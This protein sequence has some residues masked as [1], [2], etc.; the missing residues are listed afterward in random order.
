MNGIYDEIMCVT[1]SWNDG[2]RA[3]HA[4]RSDADEWEE[5][6]PNGVTL[7]GLRGMAC[8]GRQEFR[9]KKSNRR[10]NVKSK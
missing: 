5:E 10:N 2:Y 9:D 6:N 7:K 4:S 1:P 8:S 3:P